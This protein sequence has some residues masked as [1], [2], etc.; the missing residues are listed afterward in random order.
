[1]TKFESIKEMLQKALE[2][3]IRLN[4]AKK[5]FEETIRIMTDIPKTTTIED[6]V[7]NQEN[8]FSDPV[9]GKFVK[10]AV[11]NYSSIGETMTET[12]RD[13][14]TKFLD[15]TPFESENTVANEEKL[16]TPVGSKRSKTMAANKEKAFKSAVR[17][18]WLDGVVDYRYYVTKE[19]KLLEYIDFKLRAKNR[20]CRTDDL[21][22]EIVFNFSPKKKY[23]LSHVVWEAFH[24]EFRGV[25]YEIM[26]LDGD[27]KNCSLENLSIS[28]QNE[29][30]PIIR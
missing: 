8:L 27:K 11:E 22:G 20:S 24:P 25:N 2:T 29:D 16:G 17:V 4:A 13:R 26:Y 5:K 1:M 30:K 14:I 6:A 19:G 9:F 15:G 28:V 3:D 7:K 18:D 21:D 23:K 12:E 10:E